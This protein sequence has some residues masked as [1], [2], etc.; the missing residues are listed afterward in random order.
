M[1][2]VAVAQLELAVGDT[3]ANH[4]ATVA[5]ISR[6]AAKGAELVVLP[7]LSDSGYVF[8]S[9]EEARSLAFPADYRWPAGERPA[10]V[11]KARV[12]APWRCA[13]ATMT[14]EWPVASNVGG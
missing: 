9:R 14:R 12:F 6:A 1:T 5:A 4:E 3:A 8:A 7:E 2:V 13:A 11:I 10:E